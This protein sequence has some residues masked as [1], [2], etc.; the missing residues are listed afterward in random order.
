VITWEDEASNAHHVAVRGGVL[1]VRDGNFVEVVTREVVGEDTLEALGEAVLE[2]MRQEVETAES[3]RFASSCLEVAA[4]RQ[5]QNYLSTGRGR[6]VQG[7][8]VSAMT[9]TLDD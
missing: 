2:R 6:M 1:I 8:T 5:L 4:L 7:S 3:S 9:S